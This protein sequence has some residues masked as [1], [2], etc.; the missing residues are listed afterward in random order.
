MPN[1]T[2]ILGVLKQGEG[3]IQLDPKSDRPAYAYI[4]F[5]PNGYNEPAIIYFAKEGLNTAAYSLRIPAT[6]RAE[7][8]PGTLQSFDEVKTR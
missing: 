8:F 6:G 1:G 2:R 7:L 3:L 4:H 5:F